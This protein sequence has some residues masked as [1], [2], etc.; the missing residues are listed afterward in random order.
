MTEELIIAS[1]ASELARWQARWAMERLQAARPGLKCRLLTLK[2][3]GDKILDVA[4]ARIGDKGLFT[5]ELE[6]ALLRGEADI[7]VHSMKDVPTVMPEGLKITVLGP[8]EDPS[9]VLVSPY[10]YTLAGLPLRARIGTSSLRRKAQLWHHRPDL[11]IVD[12]R[13]N[14]PTRINKMMAENLDGI[15]LAAAGL[16]RLNYACWGERLPYSLVLPAVGQGAIGLESRV[17][18]Q[19]VDALLEA[20][21]DPGVS[22]AVLAE[23]AFLRALEGGCQVPIG[24]LGQVEGDCLLL[25]GMVASLDGRRMLRDFITA[26]ASR[27]EE[28][29]KRLAE[30]LLSQGADAILAE[31]R[32]VYGYKSQG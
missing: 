3:K 14:V 7:A 6:Q 30:K 12:L 23:R 31:V 4:L 2:T 25:Q 5:K 17:G 20:V 27:P 16:R 15:V 18:D 11:E 8:R 29:G 10:H 9:D 32:R 21:C 22:A 28:A 24:A 1:R 13:G 26:P 19:Q